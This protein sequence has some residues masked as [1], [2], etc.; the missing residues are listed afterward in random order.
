LLEQEF[1]VAQNAYVPMPLN[2]PYDVSWSLGFQNQ[3]PSG[4]PSASIGQTYL[5]EEGELQDIG[6][7]L[8]KI[9][10]KWASLPP[11]R[12]EIEQYAYT[13]VGLATNG[14]VQ[15]Q[16]FTQNVQSR[17]QYDYFI[18]DAL[19]ILASK[20][21]LFTDG[22]TPNSRRLNGTTGMY[23]DGLI[24]PAMQYFS[25]SNINTSFGIYIGTPATTLT[26]GDP[27]DPTTATLPNATL[28]ME[29]VTGL[30]TGNGLP[31]ELVAESS[32]FTRW[33]GN[34]WERRTRFVLAQ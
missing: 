8:S 10:R 34:I 30:G 4:F 2:T 21:Q 25:D 14:S 32:T 16:P 22:T 7:G 17:I 5:V 19:D 12:C 31:A 1:I 3:F 15:R 20:I 6:G 23:P 26:D 28:Y 9:R 29:W 33:M 18:F 24:L 11:T 27:N 13:F